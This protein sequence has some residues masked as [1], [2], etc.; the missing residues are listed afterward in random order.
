MPEM[1]RV[2]GSFSPSDRL[3]SA[4]GAPTVWLNAIV[5]GERSESPEVAVDMPPSRTVVV[6]TN[7]IVHGPWWLDS[8]AW[9]ILL[10]QSQSGVIRL[11]VP[12]LVIREATGQYRT[13][14]VSQR[15]QVQK[16]AA[17]ARSGGDMTPMRDVA[18]TVELYR[19][20]LISV[21][22]KSEATI[23]PLPEI[24][25]SM[26]ADKAINRIKPFDNSGSGFRDALLWE[27]VLAQA[28]SHPAIETVLVSNDKKAFSGGIDAS[29]HTDLGQDLSDRGIDARVSLCETV[30]DYLE[31]YG[32]PDLNLSA[33]V[34][35][36]ISAQRSDLAEIIEQR[37]TALVLKS[38]TV[39]GLEARIIA[40]SD[41]VVGLLQTVVAGPSEERLVLVHLRVV[42]RSTLEWAETEQATPQ[43]GMWSAST[44]WTVVAA[45]DRTKRG[46]ENPIPEPLSV[47]NIPGLVDEV[48]RRRTGRGVSPSDAGVMNAA[49]PEQFRTLQPTPD[50]VKA[51]AEQFRMV[52]PTSDMVKALAEQLRMVQPTFDMVKAL[53]EQFR[54]F[55]DQPM[56]Q[57]DPEDPGDIPGESTVGDVGDDGT[58]D[59]SPE[60]GE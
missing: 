1:S 23:P 50:Q 14:L 19:K 13:A 27:S 53:A 54:P 7:A 24:D 2:V 51:L 15:N 10:Y 48:L 31:K 33:Q 45:Y 49:L 57:G 6:D 44:V 4:A 22:L 58:E 42:S 60:E 39:P 56:T 20:E 34:I 18:E 37:L 40:T 16:Y 38:T 17:L 35:E 59:T 55:L 26:L 46:F 30:V 9:K 36:D 28:S 41:T 29:L 25:L 12:E 3:G 32:H 11:V 47:E 8:P 5:E 21:L 52:Q 43:T